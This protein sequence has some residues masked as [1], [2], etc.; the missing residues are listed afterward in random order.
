MLL[1]FVKTFPEEIDFFVI[2]T[3][4]HGGGVKSINGSRK[5]LSDDINPSYSEYLQPIRNCDIANLVL[6]LFGL[7]PIEGSIINK[8]QDLKVPKKIYK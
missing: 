8:S 4:D 6:Y 3:S 5:K 1:R 7:P 2:L